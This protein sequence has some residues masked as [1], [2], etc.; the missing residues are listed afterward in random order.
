[1]LCFYFNI[2]SSTKNLNA[3]KFPYELNECLYH[4]VD[5]MAMFLQ[6]SLMLW[7]DLVENVVAKRKSE[8]NLLKL[9]AYPHE[10]FSSDAGGR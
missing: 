5:D 7:L 3:L 9:W 6:N 2:K 1:M 4:Q 8:V 10:S